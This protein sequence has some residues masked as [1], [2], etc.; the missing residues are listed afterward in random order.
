MVSKQKHFGSVFWITGLSN[1][2]KSIA[3]HLQKNNRG[4]AECILLDGDVVGSYL[5]G[6]SDMTITNAGCQLGVIYDCVKESPIN[7]S[8]YFVPQFQCLKKFD[9]GD[10]KT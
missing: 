1:A 3:I 10:V 9:V 8:M 7:L 5:E 6:I 2:G 4:K